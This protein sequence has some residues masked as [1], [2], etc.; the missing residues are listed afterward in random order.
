VKTSG[1]SAD[2]QPGAAAPLA[3]ELKSK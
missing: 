2:I 3:F 1:L